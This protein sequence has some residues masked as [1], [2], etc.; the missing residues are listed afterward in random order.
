[1]EPIETSRPVPDW[2][3]RPSFEVV[4]RLA[5]VPLEVREAVRAGPSDK[6]THDRL[7]DD[8]P[9]FRQ[10]EVGGAAPRRTAIG[11]AARIAFWN[12]ER[13]RHLDA[14]SRT[15]AALSC[16]V[17]LLCEIDRGM[18]R[19]GNSDRLEDIAARLDLGYAFAVEFLELGLGDVHEQRAHLGEVNLEGL[20]GAAV[21]SDAALRAPFLIRIDRRGDWFDGRRDEPRVGGTI[22]VG[23]GIVVSGVPVLMVN[24]HLES[25]DDPAARADDM[26]RLL[27]QVELVAEGGPVVL[28]GDFNTNTSGHSERHADPAAWAAVLAADPLRLLR[29]QPFEPLFEV[30]GSFG[31]DT[32]GC[33]VE[34]APTTRY[35]AGV[36][37]PRAKIDWFFTRG[38]K[39][40][41]PKIIPAL[42]DNGEP[43]SDHDGLLLTIDLP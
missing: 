9:L 12:V 15:L 1:M 5:P 35:P 23:A 18:A 42:Q 3:G 25:H 20:H 43:S 37:R 14:I 24:V 27:Q 26:Q 8:L 2:T 17:L 10:I 28:G 11:G 29:P 4:D 31:Y 36:S 38:L 41:D 30:A 39:A 32:S 40:K 33:N 34:D 16:D 13:L 22:A 19:S 21:L 6:A 7:F